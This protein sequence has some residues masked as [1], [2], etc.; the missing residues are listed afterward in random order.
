M[1]GSTAINRYADRL[2]QVKT[3]TFAIIT[4]SAIPAGLTHPNFK[5]RTFI[6]CVYV[7]CI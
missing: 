5:F 2:V 3:E 6:Y 7:V 4:V 1:I